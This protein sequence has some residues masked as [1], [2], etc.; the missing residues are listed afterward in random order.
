MADPYGSNQLSVFVR[1]LSP[2][3]RLTI[4]GVAIGSIVLIVLLV[5]VLNRPS[6]GTLFSNVNPEDASKIV[7]RLKEQNI[8]YVL[9]DGG[10]A[11]Q[12]PKQQIY[13]LRLTFAGEGLPH[14]SVIGYE[15]F[16]RTNLGVS[17]FVQKINYRRALEGEL[18]RTILQIDEVEGARVHIVVPQKA[19]FKEDE[20]PATASVV[21]KLKSSRP[22]SRQTIQGIQHLISSSVEGLETNNVSI[23]DARGSLLSEGA[24]PNSLTALTSTQYELQQKVDNYLSQKAQT[25]MDGVLGAGNAIVQVN[26]ELDFRQVERN[27][28][29][30]DPDNTVVR[31]EQTTEERTVMSDSVAPSTRTTSLTN[32]EVNKTMEHIVESV[33]AIKRLSIATMVNGSQKTAERDGQTVSD[34]VPRTQEEMTQ[35]GDIVKRAVGF[36]QQRGDEI[37]VVN[38]QFGT[39]LQE[40]DFVTKET[41]LSIESLPDYAPKVVLIIAMIVAVLIVRSL[42]GRVRDRS[43]PGTDLG[44]SE[45]ILN[46]KADQLGAIR[47]TISLPSPEEEISE[48]VLLRQEKQKRIGEYMRTKPDDAARLLKVWLAED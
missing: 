8:P 11:I 37:S 5:S 26:A 45:S 41:P 22:L 47:R 20:K 46:G 30:Y 21:L 14:S 23:I 39:N 13:D 1:R 9:E 16:D 29:Q 48:E 44:V 6:Y 40:V 3:Q 42:L 17:D 4:G 38:M 12:V 35:L 25:L 43:V 28:E 7:E 19:L 2:A 31:S 18:A 15:I 32:Y 34:Y 27:L 33:G 36:S 24:K 10:K